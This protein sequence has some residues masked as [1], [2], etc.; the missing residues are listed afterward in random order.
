MKHRKQKK[1][2]NQKRKQTTFGQYKHREMLEQ[3]TLIDGRCINS[4]ELTVDVFHTQY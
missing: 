1:K 2:M 3:Q 4:Y